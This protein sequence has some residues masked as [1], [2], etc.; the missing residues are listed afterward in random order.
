ME[1]P[2]QITFRNM[3]KSEWIEASVRRRAAEL[4][5]YFDRIT[6]CRVLVEASNRSRHKGKTYHVRVDLTVPGDE[7]VIRRD[8]SKRQEREDIRVA[9]RDAFEAATRRLKDHA[10]R[11]R[12]RKKVDRKAATGD[13]DTET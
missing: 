10:G 5:R 8:P 11:K 1:L 9:I 4:D 2:L 13:A 12:D 6:A 3:D 7:L